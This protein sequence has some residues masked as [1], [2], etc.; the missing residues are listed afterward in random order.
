MLT[1]ILVFF[2]V[3]LFI[4]TLSLLADITDKQLGVKSWYRRRRELHPLLA[5][6]DRLSPH[7]FWKWLVRLLARFPRTAATLILLV[8]FHSW[9]HL[10]NPYA[11]VNFIQ[12]PYSTKLVGNDIVYQQ[13]HKTHIWSDP[14][15]DFIGYYRQGFLIVQNTLFGG[16]ELPHTSASEIIS[17]IHKVRFDPTKPY[18]IS[19]DQFSVLY[20]RNLGVFYNQLLD[21]NTAHDSKDWENRQR[22]YLQ[23]ALFAIDGLS[24]GKTP[25]TTLVPISPKSVIATTVHPGDVAS[26]AV[27]GTLYALDAMNSETKSQDGEYQIQT[28]LA[29][30]NILADKDDE[31]ERMVVNYLTA[32]QDKQTGLVRSDI[33]LSSARDGVTRKSSFYDN[34]IYWKTLQLADKLGVYDT[35]KDTLDAL[36]KK[37]H[38]TFWDEKLGYYK[39]DLYDDSFSSDFLIGYPTGFFDIKNDKDQQRAMKIIAYIRDNKIA[40]PLPIKYQTGQP[41]NM[42]FIIRRVVP[43]YGG[44]AIWS[45]WGAQ[46]ITLLIDLCQETKSTN[47]CDEARKDINSYDKVIVRDGGFAETFNP[48]GTFLRMGPYKSIRITGWVVQFE[49]AVNKLKLIESN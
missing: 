47:Y 29:V 9:L 16:H 43:I 38:N 10:A 19:G 46:Y 37:I 36:H 39:N 48:D 49:H 41:D 42:P 28:K 25:K 2:A 1:T 40:D 18:L 24:S 23:S 27:Y 17:D 15:T 30:K 44:E 35:P 14:I 22:I 21:P 8:L 20:P 34:V 3:S 26:D 32:V 7:R 4:V 13:H 31:L 6:L 11:G 5:R 33:K 12:Q 45:Y